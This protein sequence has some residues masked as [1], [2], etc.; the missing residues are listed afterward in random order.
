MSTATTSAVIQ[1]VC[2][3]TVL[4]LE[5]WS[6]G[7]AMYTCVVRINLSNIQTTCVQGL[8]IIIE[9]AVVCILICKVCTVG[10]LHFSIAMVKVLFIH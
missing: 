5:V 8:H 1:Y 2:V 3:D 9:D 7:F 4:V 10:C 6:I